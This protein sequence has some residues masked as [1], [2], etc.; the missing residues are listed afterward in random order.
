[1]VVTLRVHF[2]LYLF[3]LT[4]QCCVRQIL[5]FSRIE[6]GGTEAEKQEAG[7]FRFVFARN[8][9]KLLPVGHTFDFILNNEFLGRWEM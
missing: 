6:V 4:S 5:P 9:F 1:M 8:S 7:S 2:G 3:E